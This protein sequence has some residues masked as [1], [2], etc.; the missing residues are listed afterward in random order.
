MFR[1]RFAKAEDA[2]LIQEIA[3]LTWPYAYAQLLA[4]D[5]LAYMLEKMYAVP[6]LVKQIEDPDYFFLIAENEAHVAA[7]F[8]GASRKTEDLFHLQKLYVLPAFHK[9]HCGIL[10]LSE[11]QKEV[12]LRGGSQLELNVKRDNPARQFYERSGFTVKNSVDID[13]GNGYFMRDFVMKKQL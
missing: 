12:R 7:G 1:V 6:E 8:A 13:I 9:Q 10:L 2:A 3:H 11:V 5:Q 4:P